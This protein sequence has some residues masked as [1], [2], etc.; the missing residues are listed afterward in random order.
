MPNRLFWLEAPVT[1]SATEIGRHDTQVKGVLGVITS[2]RRE[3][4]VTTGNWPSGWQW[5]ALNGFFF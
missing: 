1:D 2:I 5:F 3:V 4:Y